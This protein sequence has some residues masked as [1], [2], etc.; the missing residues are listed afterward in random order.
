MTSTAA[1]RLIARPHMI[2]APG[3]PV[4]CPRL[5]GGRGHAVRH[6]AAILGHE[7]LICQYRAAAGEPECGTRVFVLQLGQGWRYVVEITVRE[8]LHLREAQLTAPEILIYLGHLPPI[9]TAR[10]I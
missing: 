6:N 3:A 10:A 2:I 8:M 7:A 9:S 1:P 5:V 4:I